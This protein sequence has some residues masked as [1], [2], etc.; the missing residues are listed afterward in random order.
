[1]SAVTM[2]SFGFGEQ[3]IRAIDRDGAAWFVGIDVCSALEL[4]N[5]RDAMNRLEEDERDCVGITDAIGR[6]R[7]TTIISESGVYALV[8][9]SRKPSAK[10]FRRWVTQEVLPALHRTG[11][12]EMVEA[13]EAEPTLADGNEN[14]ERSPLLS[15]A[16][17][18]TP[19]AV[20]ALQ[21]A[22]NTGRR[23]GAL[24][25]DAAEDAFLVE[26]G[27]IPPRAA[28]TSRVG[29][30]QQ[31]LTAINGSIADWMADRVEA[32]PGHRERVSALHADY[33]SFCH[34]RDY[35]AA[36]IVSLF[37]F[38]AAMSKCGVPNLKSNGMW[39]VGLKLVSDDG[40][41]TGVA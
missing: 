40:E 31:L 37:A 30:A 36:T 6:D 34:E 22:L 26:H 38:G 23:I 24:R 12:F 25:G 18:S 27:V 5:A 32:A 11:R 21:L 3:L 15:K 2:Q 35:D 19:R 7:E 16:L 13:G 9:T 14:D 4:S 39:R 10:R 20:Q 17:F 29:V 41:R 8:F 33:V 1:M 28:P